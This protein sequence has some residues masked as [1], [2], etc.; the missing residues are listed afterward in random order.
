MPF[1]KYWLKYVL[2]N[3]CA[4]RKGQKGGKMIPD[5]DKTCECSEQKVIFHSSE[6]QL[7]VYRGE[8]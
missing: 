1:N 7:L 5:L 2:T 3:V 4:V 6:V 8:K